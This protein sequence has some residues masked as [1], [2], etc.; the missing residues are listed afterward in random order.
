MIKL[1]CVNR[2]MLRKKLTIK[3][4]KITEPFMNNFFS[5]AQTQSP[6]IYNVT[7]HSCL[8]Y[9]RMIIFCLH[10]DFP[11]I[12][13]HK[14]EVAEQ[15]ANSFNRKPISWNSTPVV[16]NRGSRIP[17]GPK[18]HFRGS[19]MPFSRVR[20]FILFLDGLFFKITKI[21]EIL[22]V[23]LLKKHYPA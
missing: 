21:Y 6:E 13:L 9:C 22:Q 23:L 5:Y 12:T 16:P 1:L 3:C 17:G 4:W 11:V 18:Q 10:L 14:S 7:V 8:H 19:E 20:V 15:P 2:K